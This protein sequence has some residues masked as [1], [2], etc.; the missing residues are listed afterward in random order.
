MEFFVEIDFGYNLLT[1]FVKSSNLNV[2]L[3]P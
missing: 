3:V 1:L 2:W